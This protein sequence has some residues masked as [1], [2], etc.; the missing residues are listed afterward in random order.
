VGVEGHWS[1]RFLPASAKVGI[2]RYEETSYARAEKSLRKALAS[3]GLSAITSTVSYS[4]A[5]SAQRDAAA[6]VLRFQTQGVTHVMVLDNSGGITYAFMQAA[7]SQRYRPFYALTTNN[8]PQALA[9][10]AP[11]GQLA[12][13]QAVSWWNGDV[14]TR[15]DQ[16][17]PPAVPASR[18]AC[19]K[20]MA[21][22]KVDASGSATG[23]ALITCDQLLILKAVLDRGA[24]PSA[25]GMTAVLERLGTSY[26]SPLSYGSRFGPGRHDA[27]HVTRR[28]RFDAG[29]S[30]WLYAGTGPRA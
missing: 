5:S 14:G 8:S 21:D 25:A 9:Q 3:H 30:C 23:T 27:A 17:S 29:C 12:K 4:D 10:L 28:I 19:L 20:I 18:A 2:L 26:A 1:S 22:A 24:T 11:A 16:M 15:T 13:A 6:A 7:E